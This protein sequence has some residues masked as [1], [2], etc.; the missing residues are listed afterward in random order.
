MLYLTGS[1][2]ATF[3]QNVLNAVAADQTSVIVYVG[4][5]NGQEDFINYY[6]MAVATVLLPSYEAMAADIEG[7]PEEFLQRYTDGIMKNEAATYFIATMMTAIYRGKNVVLF[8]PLTAA[9]LK[10]PTALLDIL[11]IY[12]GLYASD[13]VNAFWFDQTKSDS[14]CDLMYMYDLITPQEYLFYADKFISMRAKLVYDL[15][16]NNLRPEV[17]DQFLAT[18]KANMIK[19]NRL[20]EKPFIVGV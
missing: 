12:Y 16:L 18:Y 6:K 5:P 14:I 13:G 10:Y 17:I 4:D 20:L 19:S 9:D 11:K 15:P 1:L 2:N 7:T 3:D 8:F